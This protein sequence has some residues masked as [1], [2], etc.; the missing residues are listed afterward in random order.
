MQTVSFAKLLVASVLI[1][2]LWIPLGFAEIPPAAPGADVS[3]EDGVV[4]EGEPPVVIEPPCPLPPVD[5]EAAIGIIF[6]FLDTN[7][8]AGLSLAEITAVY[9][10]FEPAWLN[11]IDVNN[12]DLLSQ[13]ELLVLRSLV[14]DT[15]DTV[16]LIDGN[17]DRLIQ[18]EEVSTVV[19]EEVFG[20]L[21]GNGNGVLDCEDLAPL[22]PVPEGEAPAEG[23][24][25]S[26]GEVVVLP[27]PLPPVD[28]EVALDMVLPY[29]D[30]DGDGGI[31]LAEITV[32]YPDFPASLFT[33][34]DPNNDGVASRS[35]LLAL[36][37]AVG[38]VVTL[39]DANGDRLIQYQEVAAVVD[40]GVFAGFDGN[41]NGVL[42]C[43]DLAPLLPVP[44]GEP[45]AEGE[46]PVEGESVG[47]PCPLP[48]VDLEVALDIVLPYLDTDGDGGLSLAEVIAIY[49][50]FEPSWFNMFD[51]NNDDVASRDELLVLR[52]VIPDSGDVIALIDGNGDRL[53]QYEEVAGFVGAA[54]FYGLDVNGNG[55]LDCEDFAALPPA[56]EGEVPWEGELPW[57]GEPGEGACPLPPVDIEVALEI[58]WPYL[59]TDGDGGLSLA[60]ISAVYPGFDP[61]W[62]NMIDANN[63][64][65]AGID[66]L[67]VFRPLLSGSEDVVL[68]ID[69]NGDRL[70]QYE[71]VAGFVDAGLFYR[72]DFNAN[73]VL[74]CED[75]AILLPVPEGEL[76]WEGEVPG[77][78]EFPWEGEPG[79]VPCPLPPVDIAVALEIA[80]PYL[81]TDGDGGLSLAEITTIYPGF[82]PAWF[83]MIDANDDGA[84]SLDELLV[85]RSVVPGGEDVVPLVDGNGDRLIQYEEVAGY[86]GEAMFSI[87]DM[88][89]N[90]VLDCEDLAALMPIGEGEV[91]WE[92]ELPWEGE[93]PWEGE[94]W[95]VPCPLPPVYLETAL[96]II[97]PYVDTDGNGGLS[98]EEITA[99]YSGFD[100]SWFDMIDT[101][102]DSLLSRDEILAASRIMTL[103]DGPVTLETILPVERDLVTL[104]D[105]NGDRLLQFSEVSAAGQDMLNYLDV[106]QNGVLD[107][108]DL[109]LL[110]SPEEGEV[111]PDPGACVEAPVELTP[112]SGR[113]GYGLAGPFDF[114]GELTKD[115]LEDPA[116]RLTGTFNFPSSGFEVLEPEIIIRESYPEQVS[117]TFRINAPAPDAPVLQVYTSITVSAEIAVANGAT[118]E[119]TTVTCT[120]PLSGEG[121]LPAEGELPPEGEGDDWGW[122]PYP[123]DDVLSEPM[124]RMMLCLFL[125]LDADGDD[126]LS[127]E[128]IT[129]RLPFPEGLYVLLDSDG[130]GVL[131]LEELYQARETALDAPAETLIQIIRTILGAGEGNFYIPGVPFTVNLQI[132]RQ[133]A[134]PVNGLNLTEILPEGWAI[135]GIVN[136]SGAGVSLK[137]D[138]DGQLLT[139]EWLNP[140]V[141]PIT[142]S[143]MVTPPADAEGIQT[144]LGQAGYD[145]L[146]ELISGEVIPTVVAELLDMVQTHT[147]DTDHDWRISLREL[148]RVIQLYNSG[149]YQ[150]ALDTED[151]YAP[152]LPEIESCLLTH[153]AD[154]SGDWVIDLPELLRVIQL[155]NSESGHYYVSD[156]TEDGFMVA[157]F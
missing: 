139:F 98:L 51:T 106:N 21:D 128:E 61:S 2:S 14:A 122:I 152:G 89:G 87:L 6:P 112:F 77:E 63:D 155:Y 124:V 110:L 45:P 7:G 23:E 4:A 37:V 44:E 111:P 135:G 93:I 91:P 115:S 29:V 33:V 28:L 97:F 129:A 123:G 19:E 125:D 36:R 84:A 144:I 64:D 58:A 145:V 76:P 32:V 8:D 39:I 3:K 141:F 154:I 126:A 41:G 40:E 137:S 48:P 95:V 54:V 46:P 86:I 68:L 96:D 121:E 80:W 74:D 151:G 133:G 16:P 127:Y 104:L 136:K 66:E 132:D 38:D 88:N 43:E 15:E 13:S 53:I 71:E 62:L 57:E 120:L 117:V 79:V 142:V 70:I 25:P 27:C 59:D 143:Y 78:G 42:D 22:L 82:E 35:E 134:E 102:N 90:G 114:T 30:T 108:E 150:C 31:S 72:L 94:T 24:P 157:P 17:G 10:E 146:G 55:V 99:V 34:V 149:G 138:P 92:G 147:A 49:P 47:Q 103:Q 148:L 1:V 60:E 109:S 118:F 18:Y 73:G 100:A 56:P 26:E 130:D 50:D 67:L 156:K 101:D 69:G 9:P 52:G 20:G 140:D 153:L 131:T 81:D 107:C 85:F 119:M 11:A 65:L 105:S 116:W 5:L 113:F 12:D 75:L 83:N